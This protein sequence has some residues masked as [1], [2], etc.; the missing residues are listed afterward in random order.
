MKKRSISLIDNLLNDPLR[1][2][3]VLLVIFHV[4]HFLA[5]FPLQFNFMLKYKVS[6]N[7]QFLIPL[8]LHCLTHSSFTLLICLVIDP[9]YWWLAIVDFGV[10][11][12]MDRLKAGP[13][14][15]GRFNDPSKSSFWISLGFDQMVHHLTDILVIWILVT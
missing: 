15:L 7:W 14:Y 1:L 6:P 9:S 2:T 4:K 12:V 13:R 10:H 5:D 11:F 3:F 8:S